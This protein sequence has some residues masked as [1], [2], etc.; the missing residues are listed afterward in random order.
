MSAECSTKE[1]NHTYKHVSL[2][3]QVVLELSNNIL[4]LLLWIVYPK[5]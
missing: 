4:P 2:C 5:G 3:F 1:K